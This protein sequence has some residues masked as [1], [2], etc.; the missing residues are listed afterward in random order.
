[1]SVTQQFPRSWL[2][3]V[4]IVLAGVALS[5]CAERLRTSRGTRI[6]PELRG[7]SSA[8]LTERFTRDSVGEHLSMVATLVDFSYVRAVSRERSRVHDQ[9]RAAY[10]RYVR[11]QTTFY[12]Y[13]VLHDRESCG[14]TRSS[15]S[16]RRSA[17]T[18]SLESSPG[19]G[20][21]AS[22]LVPAETA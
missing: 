8:E 6:P 18:L 14:P 15:R 13:L 11:R 4:V 3:L 22:V 21:T 16:K 20:T 1:M 17:G 2:S 7:L 5:G 10:E 19:N 12:V 9:E